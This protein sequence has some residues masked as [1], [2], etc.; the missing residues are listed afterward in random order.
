MLS[1]MTNKAELVTSLGVTSAGLSLSSF[2]Y[3]DI[4][5]TFLNVNDHSDCVKLT[6]EVPQDRLLSQ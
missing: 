1:V 3:R 4:Q 6:E 2:L 5:D